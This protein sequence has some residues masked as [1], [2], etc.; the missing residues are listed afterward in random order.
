V[1]GELVIAVGFQAADLEPWF[2][3][4]ELAGQVDCRYCMPDRR[5]ERARLS[6][7]RPEAPA[8]RVLAAGEVLDVRPPSVHALDAVVLAP[9]DSSGWRSEQLIARALLAPSSRNPIQSRTEPVESPATRLRRGPAPTHVCSART[10][11]GERV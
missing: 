6:L 11:E 4:V 7:P 9:S 5:T 3:Q 2:E 8:A 1:S 10:P